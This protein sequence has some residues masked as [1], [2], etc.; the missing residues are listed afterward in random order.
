MRI[1]GIQEYLCM[2]NVYLTIMFAMPIDRDLFS[3]STNLK[4]HATHGMAD[5]QVNQIVTNNDKT[6]PTNSL[7]SFVHPAKSVLA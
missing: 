2:S 5:M 6:K 4:M 7:H 1:P 3:G